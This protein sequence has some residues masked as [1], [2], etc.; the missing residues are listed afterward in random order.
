MAN[1]YPN[2]N[3]RM[4]VA[5]TN[6]ADNSSVSPFIDIYSNGF[7]LK[8]NWDGVNADGSDYIYMAIGQTIV[9]TNNIATV[10]R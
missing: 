10:A 3:V 9:G 8:S 6:G 4:L 5:N 2:S 7:K 1:P